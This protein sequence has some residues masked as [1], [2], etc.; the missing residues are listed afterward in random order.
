MGDSAL[1]FAEMLAQSSLLRRNDEE[2]A[3]C[4]PLDARGVDGSEEVG[5]RS[6][7]LKAASRARPDDFLPIGAGVVVQK[8]GGLPL[9][10]STRPP[11]SA[12]RYPLCP[13]VR[14]E[15][16]LPPGTK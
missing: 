11:A 16:L 8:Q 3:P 2:N 12:W 10:P 4:P 6:T 5:K 15:S 13:A 7:N 14:S 9:P 1:I